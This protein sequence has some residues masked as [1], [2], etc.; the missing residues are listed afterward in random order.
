MAQTIDW[1]IDYN[2]L[3]EFGDQF[4][5]R[6]VWLMMRKVHRL[7]KPLVLIPA[8][9]GFVRR[10][11]GFSAAEVKAA[12][13]RK[14]AIRNLG[15]TYDKLRVTKHDVNVRTLRKLSVLFWEAHELAKNTPEL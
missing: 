2:R 6:G 4:G 12:G 8:D 5:D 1:P 9:G 15:I 11:R 3:R 7:H 14:R 10:G 13:I